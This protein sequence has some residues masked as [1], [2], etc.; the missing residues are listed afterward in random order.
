[1]NQKKNVRNGKSQRNLTQIK[2]TGKIT[3]YVTVL[4]L[5]NNLRNECKVFNLFEC[6]SLDI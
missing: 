1:M 3:E 5:F 4:F 2:K 6:N